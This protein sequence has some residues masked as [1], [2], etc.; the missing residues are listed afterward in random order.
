MN[1]ERLRELSKIELNDIINMPVN[2]KELIKL[3]FLPPHNLGHWDTLYI[4]E[5]AI[6]FFSTH[7]KNFKDLIENYLSLYQGTDVERL[8]IDFLNFCE[9]NHVYQQEFDSWKKNFLSFI[10]ENT[11]FDAAWENLFLCKSDIELIS[12]PEFPF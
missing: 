4:S 1:S 7:P 11:T 3:E 6:P 8:K 10:H 9:I 5:V 2:D 12:I